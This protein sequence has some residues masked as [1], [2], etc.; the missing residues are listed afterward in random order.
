MRVP[1]QVL[2]SASEISSRVR[3]LG[4]AISQ[5]YG[6]GEIRVLGILK[7]ATIFLADLIREIDSPLTLDFLG[8]KSYGA[9]TVSSGQ[10]EL[11]RS[12]EE[13]VRGRDVLVVEDIVDTGHTLRFLLDFLDRE[14]ARS[15]RVAALLDKP[16]RRR[17]EVPVDYL[18]FEIPDHFVVGYGLDHDGR[19]RQLPEIVILETG[20]AGSGI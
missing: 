11:N 5:D 8:L 6:D 9:R 10:V 3:E 7:G 1:G 13:S 17:V 12:L 4:A 16:S 19:Y 20:A 14:G 18:G 15:V 2:I